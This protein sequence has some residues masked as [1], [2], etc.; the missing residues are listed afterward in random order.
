M[1]KRVDR[2][3]STLT[4]AVLIEFIALQFWFL[5]DVKSANVQYL[6]LVRSLELKESRALVT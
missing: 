6:K 1:E 5:T 4:C 3:I 2:A